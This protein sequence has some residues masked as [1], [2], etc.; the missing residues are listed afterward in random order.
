M[1][2]GETITRQALG[3]VA[4]LG[5]LY[6]ARRDCFCH[7][8]L[9]KDNLPPAAIQTAD[10]ERTNIEYINQDSIG[11]KCNNLNVES[12]LKATLLC[13]K[14]AG[15]DGHGKY[16][17]NESSTA[18]ETSITL[19]S[20]MMTKHE[21]LNVDRGEVVNLIL[22]EVIQSTQNATH[23]VVGIQWGAMAMATLRCSSQ[24]NEDKT[25]VK[26]ELKAKLSFIK[27]D[28]GAGGKANYAKNTKRDFQ[29]DFFM[30][31]L[32]HDEDVPQNVEEAIALIKKLPNLIAK[33]NG[34]KGVPITYS[35]IPISSFKSYIGQISKLDSIVCSISENAI[36]DATA[37]FQEMA[38]SL[39]ELND[40]YNDFRKHSCICI[41]DIQKIEEFRRKVRNYQAE[42]KEKFHRTIVDVR[43]GKLKMPALHS[44]IKEYSKSKF[45]R[46]RVVN[47]IDSLTSLREKI[48]YIDHLAG[49]DVHY[50]G[51]G[52][53]LESLRLEK[54]IN[55]CY[56]FFFSWKT[57][58]SLTDNKRYFND[59]VMQKK[60][61]CILADTDIQSKLSE[62]EVVPAGNRICHYKNGSYKNTDCNAK[63]LIET[64]ETDS[65]TKDSLK[66]LFGGDNSFNSSH[67]IV[68]YRKTLLKAK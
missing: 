33:A 15:V 8:Q 57:T 46:S 14:V 40:A 62:S 10:N 65:A 49:H 22:P 21:K 31:A 28:T 68:F 42:L 59:L 18:R 3:R 56:I 60:L 5:E 6:D 1:C 64:K 4:T 27:V 61:P 25:K 55:E 58:E 45:S 11:E 12:E 17:S 52:T 13:G 24:E 43:Y 66:R 41:E 38:E 48:S 9:Y 34:G 36:D 32:P 35:M 23:V 26:A 47:F 19:I 37:V 53:S 2:D 54:C 29:I 44:V 50:I 67:K 63:S 16:L 20:K 51:K 39:C 30:D 7:R